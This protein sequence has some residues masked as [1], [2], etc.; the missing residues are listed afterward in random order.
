MAVRDAYP[1]PGKCIYCLR[2]DTARTIE[3]IVPLALNGT[4]II[5]DAACAECRDKTNH[6][7]ENKAL[8][9]DSLRVIRKFL[10]LKRRRRGNDQKEIRLPP[11]WSGDSANLIYAPPP[12][13]ENP[14]EEEFPAIFAWL[15]LEPARLLAAHYPPESREKIRVV[16]TRLDGR[17][18]P[19]E[20]VSLRLQIP[21]A[22]FMLVARIG[23][24]YAVAEL[25]TDGFDGSEIRALLSDGGEN[26][27]D[28]V[29]G[30][31]G[32]KSNNSSHFHDLKITEVGEFVVVMVNLFSSYGIPPLEVIVGKR[33][34]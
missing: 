24:S 31:Y 12:L 29:G 18:V 17:S 21:P 7:Y 23:Y 8:N 9:S 6:R 15:D 1:S 11:V 32:L 25:S 10:R 14:L 20:P 4:W 33:L 3:H 2:K 34:K 13:A 19:D 27:F 22:L 30:V 5:H 28:F 26:V 16:F